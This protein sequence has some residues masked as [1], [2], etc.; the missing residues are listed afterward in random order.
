MQIVSV[1]RNI[2]F[3]PDN[4]A[5]RWYFLNETVWLAYL[6]IAKIWIAK[7]V[8]IAADTARAAVQD[9][10]FNTRLNHVTC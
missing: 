8:T 5:S 6:C 3:T 1:C 7:Y 9:Y 10:M 4:E 2:F